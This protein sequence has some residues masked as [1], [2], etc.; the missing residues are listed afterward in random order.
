MKLEVVFF[1]LNTLSGILRFWVC[2]SSLAWGE[3]KETKFIW[4]SRTGNGQS[5]SLWKHILF[6]LGIKSILMVPTI[7]SDNCQS[8]QVGTQMLLM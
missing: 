6:W 1:C 3:G 2:R 7:S 8:D 4:G 5:S